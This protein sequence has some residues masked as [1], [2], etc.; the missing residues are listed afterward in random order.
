[1]TSFDTQRRVQ[2]LIDEGKNDREIADRLLITP[3]TVRD[4]RNTV[5][6]D[7]LPA[8][9][10]TQAK[11]ASSLSERVL[12]LHGN[13]TTIPRIAR[14][15]RVTEQYAREVIRAAQADKRATAPAQRP[16]PQPIKDKPVMCLRDH[17]DEHTC[18]E[19]ELVE[20]EVPKVVEVATVCT[21]RHTER[22]RTVV[23]PCRRKH[24]PTVC[25]VRHTD[26]KR[27]PR[28]VVY[29]LCDRPHADEVVE[30]AIPCEHGGLEQM[31]DAMLA[32]ADQH[33]D[34]RVRAYSVGARVALD[35]MAQRLDELDDEKQRKAERAAE[36]ARRLGEL[37]EERRRL[38]AEL[39]ELDPPAPDVA[40]VEQAE[41]EPVPE[42]EPAPAAA[43]QA[44]P[45][46]VP[47]PAGFEV[48]PGPNPVEVITDSL[49]R[50]RRITAEG[51]ER[52]RQAAIETT[53]K[54]REKK[55]KEQANA[56]TATSGSAAG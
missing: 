7:P 24:G 11:A 9:P 29:Q 43:E 18:P 30:R 1:M 53:R 50:Q 44:Q 51:R 12:T 33:E 31:L 52:Q 32:E 28:E 47:A 35:L 27:Q 41:P 34:E 23:G 13:G 4:I 37:D 54:R 26:R 56:G 49:G 42:P 10:V 14:D 16:A 3:S 48:G 2:A 36:V 6:V 38:L 22:V 40:P 20:V 15:L 55:E 8:E 19:P 21:L 17:L 45:T 25:L 46:P 39:D 5:T